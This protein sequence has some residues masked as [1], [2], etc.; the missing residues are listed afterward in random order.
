MNAPENYWIWWLF[1]QGAVTV[2]DYDGG[3]LQVDATTGH[4][5]AD[6][7][8][9]HGRRCGAPRRSFSWRLGW[10]AP[11]R[12]LSQHDLPWMSLVREGGEKKKKKTTP[13]T[14][15]QKV[16]EDLTP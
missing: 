7:D 13:H 5:L 12:L 11:S 15:T 3:V 6:L 2:G 14:H 16:T 10:R 4:F 9:H 8:A 1:V